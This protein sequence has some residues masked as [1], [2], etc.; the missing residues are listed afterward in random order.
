[1]KGQGFPAGV[2]IEWLEDGGQPEEQYDMKFADPRKMIYPPIPKLR[3]KLILPPPLRD[4]RFTLRAMTKADEEFVMNLYVA[5]RWHEVEPLVD[6]TMA[7]K[8]AF[9]EHQHGLQH[10]HYLKAHPE[11]DFMILERENFDMARLYLD[12]R[13]DEIQLCDI[14]VARVVQRQGLGSWLIRSVQEEGYRLNKRVTLHVDTR[15]PAQRLYLGLGFMVVGQTD[16]HLRMEWQPVPL[17]AVNIQT[18]KPSE[19]P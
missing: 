17:P 8:I 19:R 6:W 10:M 16:T 15:N 7:Q 13:E 3:H 2:K 9:L 1:M 5:S 11:G 14:S 4:E 12:Y 18:S